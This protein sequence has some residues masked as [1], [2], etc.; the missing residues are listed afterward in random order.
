M[1]IMALYPKKGCSRPG[2]GHKIYP[3]WLKGLSIDR[4]NQVFCTDITYIP[5]T[6]GFVYLVAI[7][8][9][10]SLKYEDM[11]LKAYDLVNEARASI[12]KYIGFYNAERKYQAL[13]KTPTRLVLE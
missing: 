4:P 12:R 8:D 11:Y 1:G 10:R 13:E 3:Y 7:M 5:M 6:K 2:K 9:W